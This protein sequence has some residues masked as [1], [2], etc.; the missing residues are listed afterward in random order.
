M[1]KKEKSQVA[2]DMPTETINFG[3]TWGKWTVRGLYAEEDF[4]LQDDHMTVDMKTGQT[5]IDTSGMRFSTIQKGCLE[6]PHGDNPPTN[7]LRRLPSGVASKLLEVIKALS[8]PE[9][10]VEKN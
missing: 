7:V 5:N 4:K 9:P 3:N 2:T 1:T 8:S 6:S 10:I